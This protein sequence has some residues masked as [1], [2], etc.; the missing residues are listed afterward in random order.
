M[1]TIANLID[2]SK[3]CLLERTPWVLDYLP[4]IRGKG[5][6]L[7]YS[8]DRIAIV[9]RTGRREIWI[10]RGNAVYTPDMVGSFDYYFN[11]VEPF[12]QSKA[13]GGHLIVDYSSSRF[14]QVR[15]FADF[16]IL[17]PSLVEPYQTC[18]QYLEFAQLRE[19]QTVFDLGSYSGLTTIAFSKAVNS[20]GRVIAVEPDPTNYGA[21]RQNLDLNRR[22][23]RLDN[24]SL[25]PLAIAGKRGML[26]FSSEASMGS[27]AVSVVGGYRGAVIEIPCV[28]LA[29]LVE[30][31]GVERVDFIKMDIEGSEFDAIRNAEAFF[32]DHRPR[33]IVE[34]HVVNGKLN[35][36]DLINLMN[37]YG[38]QCKVIEQWGVPLP[39]VTAIPQ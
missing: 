10:S 9:D 13:A 6:R 15:G 11:A 35:A 26:T 5:Y 1:T 30:Q 8:K 28:S 23:N 20:T 33:L 18:E 37:G 3:R 38:Y 2:L 17:C 4:A 21:C 34:S 16:P 24:V 27:S 19:G 32:R 29:D 31:S 25:L 39:L 12:R 7:T 14:H 22:L 36:D